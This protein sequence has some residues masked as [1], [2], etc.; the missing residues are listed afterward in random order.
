M[1]CPSVYN[2]GPVVWQGS[3]IEAVCLAFLPVIATFSWSHRGE[4][5]AV[6]IAVVT[7]GLLLS[8]R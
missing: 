4:H 8:Q 3:L 6:L 7:H 5:S 2:R 1:L